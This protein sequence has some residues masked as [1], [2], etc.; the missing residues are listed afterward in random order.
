MTA[1]VLDVVEISP[2]SVGDAAGGLLAVLENGTH[3]PPSFAVRRL[4]WVS[5][6]EPGTRRGNHAHRSCT[7][8]LVAVEG[9]VRVV[10]N[11]GRDSRSFDLEKGGHAILIPPLLWATQT[12]LTRAAT[13]L[14][15]C[16][17]PYAEAEY[18]RDMDEYRALV[19]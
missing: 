13:L 4:F 17:E 18:I 8:V 19:G 5:G 9:T 3:L 7:Q 2:Q 12:Y 15:L 16:D 11:D 10:V 14:V 6:V 1:S